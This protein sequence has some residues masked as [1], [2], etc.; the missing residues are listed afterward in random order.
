[1]GKICLEWPT[2][3]ELVLLVVFAFENR[4]IALAKRHS[5]ERVADELCA[6]RTLSPHILT[7][8][9]LSPL[10][11]ALNSLLPHSHAFF[12]HSDT[13]APWM[14]VVSSR[15]HAS[16]FLLC[17]SRAPKTLRRRVSKPQRILPKLDRPWT[18][19]V[20]TTAPRFVPPCVNRAP[21]ST[22]RGV[23]ATIKLVFNCRF[24]LT[25]ALLDSPLVSHWSSSLSSHFLSR[26]KEGERWPRVE[27]G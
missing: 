21:S 15:G 18:P 24:S 23:E 4:Q 11:P 7:G 10:S 6:H 8:A 19:I 25:L 9:R 16:T 20:D 22:V 27:I 13:A 12:S 2:L 26:P 3:E 14:L 5:P 1:M 17:P